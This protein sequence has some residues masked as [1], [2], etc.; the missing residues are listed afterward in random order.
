MSRRSALAAGLLLIA[1]CGD[2]VTPERRPAYGFDYFGDVFHWP[3]DRLP[4]RFY[5]QPTGNLRFLTQRA[6]DVWAGQFLYG[7]FS[8]RLV[9]DSF[10]ADVIVHADSAPDVPPDPGPPVSACDGNVHSPGSPPGTVTWDPLTKAIDGPLQLDVRILGAYSTG[11]VAACLR[12]TTI[13]ELGHTLGLL[14]HS[15]NAADIMYAPPQVDLPS[16]QD[17]RTVEVLY[18]T[19]PTLL[20][21]P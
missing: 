11:Q 17:R 3:A 7:E 19:R 13:H 4:V 16:E 18:H 21:A 6:I 5:A 10:G 9:S 14:Q 12:R 8:G 20:P 1:A 2:P 15:P